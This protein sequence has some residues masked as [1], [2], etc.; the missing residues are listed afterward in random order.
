MSTVEEE[1]TPPV[2]CSSRASPTSGRGRTTTSQ[3]QEGEVELAQ[4]RSEPFLGSA[5]SDLQDGTFGKDPNFDVS[6]QWGCRGRKV[7]RH[8]TENL[9]P[10]LWVQ[11]LATHPSNFSM[12][13]CKT[14][15]KRHLSQGN[16]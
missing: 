2:E 7:I 16:K 1:P 12:L 9:D 13:D 8:L 10:R 15:L 4:S 5:N 14:K 6:I 11:T 3:K